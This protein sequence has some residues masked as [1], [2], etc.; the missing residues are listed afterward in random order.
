VAAAASATPTIEDARA[1][2]TRVDAE[3]RRL[4]VA[5]NHAD[6]VNQT[7][8]TEDSDLLSSQASE[9]SMTY[10][11]AAIL[12]ARRYLAIPNLPPDLARQL[13]LL[14]V[15]T[16]LPAPRDA[17][18]RAELA[19]LPVD[20]QSKY[21]A[22]QYCPPKGSKLA[23]KD[24]SC[25]HLDDLD[26][27]IGESRDPKVLE[28][29]WTAWHATARD[30]RKTY[31]R[32]VELAN[33]GARDLGWSDLGELWRAGYDM[34][35]AEFEAEIAR[36]WSEVKPLYQELHCYA[37][38]RLSKKYGES[39][40][41][42]TGPIPA[43]MLGNMWAQEWQALYP[44]LEPYPNQASLDVGKTLVAKK[45]APTDMV[46]LGESAFL[47]LGFDKLPETFWKRSLFTR[48]KDRE[49]VCHA[50]AWDV[51]Y[52]DDLRI[53]MCIQPT[54]EDLITIHHE[55]GHD[56][57]FQ[58]YYQLP[59][60]YQ[61][62][63]N[64]GFHEGIGDT[65][66]L[67]VTPEYLK[68]K[69]LLAQ[70]P[71]DEKGQ[72]DV[73]FKRALEKIAFLPFGLLVDKWRWEVFAGK[74]P[75]NQWNAEWW[76]LRKEFQG[77]APPT[78]RGEEFFD[79]AAKFHVVS[80]VPYTRYFLAAIY[81]FQFH[82]ALCKAA[83]HTGPLYKCSIFGNKN[84]GEKLRAMLALG[85]SKPWPEALAMLNGEKRADATAILEYFE[86]LRAVL[87]EE[88]KGETCGY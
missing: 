42:K 88:T 8:I 36:L 10:Q 9:A 6:W 73:M 46:R 50:S 75:E 41:P 87:K 65:L 12:E 14:A 70:T 39:V 47:S 19:K 17:K 13:H 82:R 78:A 15:S 51:E 35:P 62:G 24:G 27:L 43:H 60:L 33:E 4:W 32:F 49:V 83:G 45:M 40:I 20:M 64:D 84:A 86:P 7:Y 28:E 26:R 23:T 31:A 67:S 66:A 77:V 11:G 58:S 53:K 22:A 72:L 34:S 80:N 5:Q 16:S 30:Q 74:V 54:E 56:F 57:Y 38:K 37:R 21:G 85:A 48:P 55:L 79:P 59:I 76:R 61:Q 81:Q 2:L 3:L 1:F 71:K 18:K 44:M 52:A 29:A 68:S 25:L 63:A 69:G